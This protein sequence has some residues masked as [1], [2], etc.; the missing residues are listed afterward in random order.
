LRNKKERHQVAANGL[1]GGTPF[2]AYGGQPEGIRIGQTVH[3]TAARL[4]CWINVNSAIWMTHW[5]WVRESRLTSLAPICAPQGAADE[6]DLPDTI[7]ST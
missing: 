4:R 5:N 1:A 6:L 3:G 7:S 2:G